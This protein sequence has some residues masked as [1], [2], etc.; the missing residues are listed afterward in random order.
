[1]NIPEL[2]KIGK[3]ALK[4]VG[5]MHPSQDGKALFMFM[6]LEKTSICIEFSLTNLSTGIHF[7]GSSSFHSRRVVEAYSEIDGERKTAWYARNGSYY[8]W[9]RAVVSGEDEIVAAINSEVLTTEKK[10]RDFD[11]IACEDQL[12]E[13]LNRPGTHQAWYLSTLAARKDVEKLNDM[14][15]SLATEDRGGLLPYINEKFITKA[16]NY[17]SKDL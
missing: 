15:N 8:S 13:T 14:L 16:I 17:A 4:K 2:R 1:M 9:N 5:Y 6:E 12:L 7:L 10:A 11:S 3:E